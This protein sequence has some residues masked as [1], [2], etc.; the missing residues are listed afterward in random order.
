MK[1]LKEHKQQPKFLPFLNERDGVGK[2][3][4]TV[5]THIIMSACLGY[6]ILFETVKST[7]NS[8]NQ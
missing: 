7:N 6:R 5:S 8:L 1:N 2:I 3:I 4:D